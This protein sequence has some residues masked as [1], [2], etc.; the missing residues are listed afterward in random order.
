MKEERKVIQIPWKSPGG[1]YA[2]KNS[3]RRMYEN[4]KRRGGSK[5]FE[6]RGRRGRAG[7]GEN[8]CTRMII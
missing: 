2:S 1:S 4:E 8:E 3:K 6:T 5:M 7:R